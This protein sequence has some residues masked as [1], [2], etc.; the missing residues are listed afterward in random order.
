MVR[1]KRFRD[2]LEPGD[3]VVVPQKV[4]GG[5]ARKKPICLR[6]NTLF[7]WIR[8]CSCTA[9]VANYAF[10]FSTK[11]QSYSSFEEQA[12]IG[13][14]R[15]PDRRDTASGRRKAG[16]PVAKDEVR[17][18]Q[19]ESV[20]QIPRLQDTELGKPLAPVQKANW[21]E[22]ASLFWDSRRVFAR[23][24]GTVFVL[25]ILVALLLPKE[26]VSGAR[27][28]PPEQGGILQRCL[29]H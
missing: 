2:K 7:C 15:Q 29:P 20:E 24:A 6:P 18:M 10:I 22:N 13:S 11:R 12:Y 27:I 5:S 26:Y 25:S 28:M 19:T 17:L 16:P 9:L 14:T 8:C 1:A 3:V 4:F 21:V 23:V